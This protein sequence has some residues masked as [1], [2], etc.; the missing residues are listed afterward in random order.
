MYGRSTQGYGKVLATLLVRPDEIMLELGAGGELLVARLRAW[1]SAL[2][3]LLPLVNAAGGGDVDETVIGLAAAVFV[4]IMAQVWLVL[5]RG[6]RRHHWL[7]FATCTYDISTTTGVLV[8]LALGDRAA[9]MNSM[10]VWCFYLVAIAMTALRN[11]GRLTLYAGLLSIAQYALLAWTLFATAASPDQLVSVDYGTATV[12]NQGMRLVL[13]LIMT[14]LTATIVYRMQR[15]VELSGRDGLTGLPNRMWLL[16]QMPHVLD[17]LRNGGGS[18][19]LVLLDLDRFRLINDEIGHLDGDRAIRHVV[20]LL[21]QGVHE[22]ERLI[23]LGGEEFVLLLHCPVGSGWERIEQ[24]RRTLY[25]RPFQP[26]RGADLQR[27]T[28]SAG[29]AAWPQDG[30]D[31]SALL[32]SA[33]RRLQA[34][35]REGG[36]RVMARDG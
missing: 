8:L 5:A 26:G 13:L 36:N 21:A 14:L 17:S 16:Q 23:R 28:F 2:I 25:D 10:V 11:D 9:G 34:C 35:K 18:L 12:A 6:G 22:R 20:A 32:G 27:I 31:L 33:D 29:L 7:P 4:N 19:T 24:L 30:A 3:L 1:L 15:L